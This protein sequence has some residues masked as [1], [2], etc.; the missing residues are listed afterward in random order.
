MPAVS[1]WITSRRW[2]APYDHR[3][4]RRPRHTRLAGYLATGESTPAA[5]TAVASQA[6]PPGV[7]RRRGRAVATPHR[8]PCQGLVAIRHAADG[9]GDLLGVSESPWHPGVLARPWSVADPDTYRFWPRRCGRRGHRHLAGTL[10]GV[11]RRVRPAHRIG[12]ANPGDRD[13]PCRHPAVPNR[14]GRDRVHHI[15]G[16]LLPD[17]GQHPA[18]R[19]RLADD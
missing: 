14:R 4:R 10:S 16:R 6:G 8:E 19:A 7:G 5:D 18:R 17:H 9:H 12:S 13:S 15:P 3:R 1:R 2:W 11:L